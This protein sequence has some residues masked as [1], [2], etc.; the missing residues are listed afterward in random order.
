MIKSFQ[1]YKNTS[2]RFIP[3]I[4][5]HW[6]KLR[7]KNL[8]DNSLYY[9][10]GDGDHGSIKPEMYQEDGVPYIRVQNLSWHGKLNLKKVVYISK[11]V[12]I[13]NKKS[14]LKPGDILI[15]KT[16]ATIGKLSRWIYYHWRQCNRHH[17]K[18]STWWR[19]LLP[20]QRL[21]KHHQLH[22]HHQYGTLWRSCRKLQRIIPK[23]H[24]MPVQS[25]SSAASWRSSLELHWFSCQLHQL[26]ILKKYK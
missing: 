9:P 20:D 11:E 23:L 1:S 21:S 26:S 19:N 2:S 13:A 25:K 18:Y 12:Q 10:V 3:R 4:P 14:I 7:V 17:P 16:G 5:T 6:K 15:A 8:V 22:I 24:Q